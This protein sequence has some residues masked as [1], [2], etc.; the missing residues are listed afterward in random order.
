MAAMGAGLFFPAK[1]HYSF[2]LGAI[3]MV[4]LLLWHKGMQWWA[5]N[6]APNMG[7]NC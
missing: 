7:T 5:S 1:F 3:F 6:E 2:W 4:D